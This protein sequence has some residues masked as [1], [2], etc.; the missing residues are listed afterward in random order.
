MELTG[1]FLR[2]IMSRSGLVVSTLT[3]EVNSIVWQEA[4]HDKLIQMRALNSLISNIR[5]L[6]VIKADKT[7]SN[8]S[9]II[10]YIYRNK[11]ASPDSCFNFHKVVALNF[12]V[13]QDA[14]DILAFCT[15]TVLSVLKKK[16][17]QKKSTQHQY[18]KNVFCI[19]FAKTKMYNVYNVIKGR[20]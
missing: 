6:V 4:Y 14:F 5:K 2:L 17:R 7:T 3:L 9:L 16:K 20:I 10:K 12:N 13:F 19:L 15:R 18:T 1:S 11:C 8:I